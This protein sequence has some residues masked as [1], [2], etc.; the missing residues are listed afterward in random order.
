MMLSDIQ[1]RKPISKLSTS[2]PEFSLI[3][4]SPLL[5]SEETINKKKKYKKNRKTKKNF[6]DLKFIIIKTI[7]IIKKPC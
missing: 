1:L 5:C 6:Y 4:M 7:F 3:S 2:H